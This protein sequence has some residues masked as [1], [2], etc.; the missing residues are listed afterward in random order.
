MRLIDIEK[1]KGCAIVRPH[2]HEDIMAVESCSEKIA[3]K[4]IPTAFDINTVM[5]HLNKELELADDEKSRCIK[6]NPM[7]FDEAKGY[8]RGIATAIEILEGILLAIERIKDQPTAEPQCIATV[9]VDFSKGDVE[10]LV[11]QYVKESIEI[12]FNIDRLKELLMEYSYVKNKMFKYGRSKAIG[13]KLL[14]EETIDDIIR[15]IRER[16]NTY[17]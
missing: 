17:V 6:E 1:L 14:D 12:S 3:H 15:F 11:K 4:D 9:K 5:E 16:E 2:T 7:Q 8:A 13:G 10:K